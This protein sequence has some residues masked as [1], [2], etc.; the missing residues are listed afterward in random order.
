MPGKVKAVFF[1]GD[2]F[3]ANRFSER[4]QEVIAKKDIVF[5]RE[6]IHQRRRGIRNRRRNIL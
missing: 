2:V 3:L 6:H 4:P 1:R 5:G